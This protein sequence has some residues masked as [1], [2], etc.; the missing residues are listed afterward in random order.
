MPD[1]HC[2]PIDVSNWIS[3]KH[4]LLFPLAT[5]MFSTAFS[6][7]HPL[8]RT[9][10]WSNFAPKLFPPSSP[11]ASPMLHQASSECIFHDRP[12][13]PKTYLQQC[14]AITA[15]KKDKN[16]KKM[17]KYEEREE[18]KSIAG[19]PLVKLHARS[20]ECPEISPRRQKPI[21]ES[22]LF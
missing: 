16:W 2:R 14:T 7:R 1:R 3:L 11:H 9:C 22:N 15:M 8:Q 13:F 10:R 4:P 17:K 18:F 19:Q 5:G 21:P 20:L 6:C 12:K